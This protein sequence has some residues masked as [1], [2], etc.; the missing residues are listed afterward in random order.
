MRRCLAI[1][2]AI[3]ATPAQSE[4]A[5]PLVS[6]SRTPEASTI[7]VEAERGWVIVTQLADPQWQARGAAR[8]TT[9]NSTIHF[10][11]RF[12]RANEPG[13]LAMRR[14]SWQVDLRL[15]YEAKVLRSAWAS[16]PSPGPAG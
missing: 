16:H 15:E 8:N 1:G 2:V 13:W 7:W 6:E 3:R 11:Q 14:D 10:A 9:G 4:H 12:R 5:T